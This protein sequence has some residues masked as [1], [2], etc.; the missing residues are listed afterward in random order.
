MLSINKPILTVSDLLPILP[1]SGSTLKR[2]VKEGSFPRPFKI[3]KQ[4]NGW[5]V[6]EIKK[7]FDAQGVGAS[8]SVGLDG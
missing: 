1:F 8:N 4:L 5:R 7:W 3:T 6:E 2:K